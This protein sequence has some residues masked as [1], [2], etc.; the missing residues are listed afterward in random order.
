M[1]QRR[2]TRLLAAARRRH[3]QDGIEV[4]F[5]LQA[6]SLRYDGLSSVESVKT[7]W[8]DKRGVG[9]MNQ[10][11]QALL[12]CLSLFLLTTLSWH[13][14]RLVAEVSPAFPYLRWGTSLGYVF[15][16]G[17]YVLIFATVVL[18]VK[19]IDR[20]SLQAIG[21]GKVAGWRTYVILGILFHSWRGSW[22][23][24]PSHWRVETLLW[25]HIPLLP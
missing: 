10:G 19:V 7:V 3:H 5:R 1:V 8:P 18:F 14:Y 23:F 21:L 13:T 11:F 15:Y 25:G 24:Y 4:G 16:L 17:F 2:L 22:R 12:K 20:S 9:R 6:C